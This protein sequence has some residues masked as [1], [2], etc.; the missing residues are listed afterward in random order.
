MSDTRLCCANGCTTPAEFLVVNTT[1]GA[2]PYDCTDACED[3]VG[4]VLGSINDIEPTEW[5]VV[6]L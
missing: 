5:K 2:D 1:P 3:H 4:T 6:A